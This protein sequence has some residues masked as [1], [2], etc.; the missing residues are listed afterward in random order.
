MEFHKVKQSSQPGSTL[1]SYRNAY[2][3]V[4]Q[5]SVPSFDNTQS[6]LSNCEFLQIHE[7]PKKTGLKN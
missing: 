1:E 5:P 6:F 3:M 7:S 4:L 2:E